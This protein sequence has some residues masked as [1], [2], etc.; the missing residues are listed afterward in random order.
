V[1]DKKSIIEKASLKY[2]NSKYNTL[3]RAGTQ[4]IP[5]VG[6]ALDMLLSGQAAN[7]QQ[8]RLEKQIHC[9]SERLGRVEGVL[10]HP[11]TEELYDLFLRVFENTT[12]TRS[13]CKREYFAEILA[14]KITGKKTWEEAEE[15]V[16]IISYLDDIHIQILRLVYYAQNT[17]QAIGNTEK[18]VS[19]VATKT[20]AAGM[21]PPTIL[22]E[23]LPDYSETT[24]VLACSEL[25]SRGLLVD[26]GVLT[27]TIDSVGQFEA[28]NY[29]AITKA[30]R[31]FIESIQ[32]T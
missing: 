17:G 12:K 18:W 29:F 30:G 20:R 23:E 22:K 13:D 4:L 27:T 24:L 26:V 7:Y 2:A 3:M 9:I 25:M 14:G 10:D 1:S 6:G 5:G 31:H 11:L 15:Y 21:D 32:E 16:R 28:L 19:V 8:E